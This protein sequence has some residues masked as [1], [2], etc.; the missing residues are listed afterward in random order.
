MQL[1][2]DAALLL[3]P[4]L[5]RGRGEELQFL[6]GFPQRLLGPNALGHVAKDH[7]VELVAVLAQLRDRSVDRKFLAVAA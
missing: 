4:R 3:L 7:G 2:G 1:A 6:F 5:V